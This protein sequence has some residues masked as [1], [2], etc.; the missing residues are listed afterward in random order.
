MLAAERDWS[1]HFSVS[2]HLLNPSVFRQV[3]SHTLFSYHPRCPARPGVLRRGALYF[4][5]TPEYFLG[6]NPLLPV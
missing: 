3:F 5:V 1:S 6:P 2:G 4:S